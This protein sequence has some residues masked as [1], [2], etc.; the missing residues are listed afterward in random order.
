MLSITKVTS[1]LI[2]LSISV[3]SSSQTVIK[4]KNFCLHETVRIKQETKRDAEKMKHI[5]S[6]RNCKNKV[7]DR[8][9]QN[10][11]YHI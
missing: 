1:H 9:I 4:K 11:L 10:F 8:Y 5:E 7:R 2:L 6:E 3:L